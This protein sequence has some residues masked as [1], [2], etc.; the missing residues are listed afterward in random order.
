MKRNKLEVL[1]CV[2]WRIIYGNTAKNCP[3]F[4]SLFESSVC[5]MFHHYWTKTFFR[6]T[7]L[8]K[9]CKSVSVID[10]VSDRPTVP[11][12]TNTSIAK[13][14]A[15]NRR[16]D[17]DRLYYE[18]YKYFRSIK[19]SWADSCIAYFKHN[20]VS[21]THLDTQSFVDFKNVMRMSAWDSIK[22]CRLEIFKNH[23]KDLA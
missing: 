17:I 1:T 23:L 19:R 5:K 18:C 20:N 7:G 14:S 8:L 3:N 15:W 22:F 4:E 16:L 9:C 6:R 10:N 12:T 11:H 2:T 13:R 21:E